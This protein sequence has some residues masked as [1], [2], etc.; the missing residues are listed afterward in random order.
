MANIK[1]FWKVDQ[2]SRSKGKNFLVPIEM[3]CHK[4]HTYEI[5]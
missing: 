3:Y 4:E 2:T 1:S 5:W